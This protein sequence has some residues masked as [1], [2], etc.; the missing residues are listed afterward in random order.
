MSSLLMF[1]RVYKT[2]DTV[3]HVELSTQLCE[4]TFSLVHLPTSLLPEVKVQ[5]IQK[6]CGWK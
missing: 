4:L 1:N 2:G 6:E 3:S 5:Y